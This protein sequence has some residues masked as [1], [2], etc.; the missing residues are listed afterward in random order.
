[1]ARTKITNGP[2]QSTTR[3][4][5]ANTVH[6]SL[7]QYPRIQIN[8]YNLIHIINRSNADSLILI[9]GFI[10]TRFTER[11]KC[12]HGNLEIIASPAKMQTPDGR[13]M[14]HDGDFTEAM[15]DNLECF[16]E[17]IN[18]VF[19]GHKK[20]K[21]IPDIMRADDGVYS[22]PIRIQLNRTKYLGKQVIKRFRICPERIRERIRRDPLDIKLDFVTVIVQ[23]PP[24][25]ELA[26]MIRQLAE[27]RRLAHE[28]AIANNQFDDEGFEDMDDGS[29]GSSD[30]DDANG[31]GGR[32]A[33][34][35]VEVEEANGAEE[36]AAAVDGDET[37]TDN[38]NAGDGGIEE[39][40]DPDLFIT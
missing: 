30:D 1:M 3:L 16:V 39:E 38:G 40:E 32:G 5:H 9:D 35:G 13:V 24:E 7:T 20:M 28:A 34:A 37:M 6:R 11:W 33:I 19:I 31:G 14:E 23:G 18:G 4:A 10:Q 22:N 2:Y 8:A 29:A 15:I 21:S 12:T 26:D 27:E 25:D 36:E 17:G